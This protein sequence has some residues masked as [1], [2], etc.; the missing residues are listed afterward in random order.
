ME[1]V[2]VGRLTAI[3]GIRVLLEAFAQACAQRPDLRLKLV[4][5]G[6]DRPHLETLASQI[7]DQTGGQVTFTGFQSQAQV[8][9][10]LA[11]ADMFVLPS[12]AEGVPVVLMEA[13]ASAKPVIATQVAGIPELITH[14]QS[15]FL[16]PAG[17]AISLA[18]HIL[19]LAGDPELRARMGAAGRQKVVAEFNINIEAARIATLLAGHGPDHEP[20]H[21]PQQEQGQ[22]RV[23]PDPYP[24]QGPDTQ[25]FDS[26]G[27]D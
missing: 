17:D 14:G 1:L 6:D 5:D 7:T 19:K 9:E 10:H 20:D 27:S 13:M 18:A 26:R 2:F 25:G 24:A 11:G 23:R 4:G 21:G 16:A 22:D 3:K 15:G 8:A 12:F